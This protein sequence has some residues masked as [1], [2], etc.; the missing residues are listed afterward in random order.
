MYLGL[1]AELFVTV[2][3]PLQRTRRGSP[4]FRCLCPVLSPPHE[5]PDRLTTIPTS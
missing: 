2:R 1:V 3:L 4:Q 5:C